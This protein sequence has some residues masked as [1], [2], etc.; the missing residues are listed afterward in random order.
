MKTRFY[1]TIICL[2]TICSTAFIA[3][4]DE[5]GDVTKPVINL[6]EP[7]EG[8]HLRIGDE[9][10]VHFDM[11]LSDDGMLKSYRINIHNNFDDHGHATT[12]SGETAVPFTFD[13]VYDISGLKNTH[14][15]HHD[16][17]IPANATPGKYHLMVWCTDEAGNQSE[18]ARNIV[19]SNEAETN[20]E[21]EH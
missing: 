5:A 20:P 6:L 8:A 7:E 18:V 9:H 1:F 17:K 4:D 10:G 2:F 15:H 19:L 12:K 3:C 11:D 14:I 13:K 21:H 16:I